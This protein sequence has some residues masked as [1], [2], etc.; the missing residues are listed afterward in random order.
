MVKMIS[1]LDNSNQII[2]WKLYEYTAMG[3][4][5]VSSNLPEVQSH[6]NIIKIAEQ[7]IWEKRVNDM[8]AIIK[9][10]ILKKTRLK[11]RL[12]NKKNSTE[13]WDEIWKL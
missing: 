2:L 6:K 9:D 5:I 3:K 4:P 10:N 13:S 12:Y 7:N 8:L 1:V 11:M